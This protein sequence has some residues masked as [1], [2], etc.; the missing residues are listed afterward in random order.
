MFWLVNY[1]LWKTLLVHFGLY[2][3]FTVEWPTCFDCLL[4]SLNFFQS[5]AVCTFSN[6]SFTPSQMHCLDLLTLN[7]LYFWKPCRSRIPAI[8]KV[9]KEIRSLGWI[10]FLGDSLNG[11]HRLEDTFGF[12]GLNGYSVVHLLTVLLRR[13]CWQ[14]SRSPGA[15][16]KPQQVVRTVNVILIPACCYFKLCLI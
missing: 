9:L 16:V 10:L 14:F 2:Y 13:E 7:S 4:F 1:Q 5:P 3:T 11:W 8:A 15:V 6:S 12:V